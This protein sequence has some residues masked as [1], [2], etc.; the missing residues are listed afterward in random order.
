MSDSR[1]VKAVE[2]IEKNLDQP[3]DIKDV[4]LHCCVST[5]HLYRIFKMSIGVSVKRY[6]RDRRLTE[7]S[8]RCI[9][10][11]DKINDIAFYFQFESNSN[12][13]RAFAK[14]FNMSP[15]K[16]RTLRRE[17]LSDVDEGIV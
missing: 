15:K 10:T 1:A 17:G 4:A 3:I 2:F 5:R 7:A 13:S 16:F 8:K 9:N 12:F 14:K 6:M 11:D